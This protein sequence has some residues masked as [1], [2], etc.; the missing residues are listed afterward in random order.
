LNKNYII[1][2]N[3]NYV[4]SYDYSNNELYHKYD[5]N[6]KG[7]HFILIIHNS[8][9]IIKLIESCEDG[10]IRIWHF[11]SGLLLNKIKII[12]D[13][14]NGICLLND[15]YYLFVGCDD[16]TIK[17]ID[18]KNN[19]IINEI[20]GHYKPVLTIKTFIHPKMGKCLISQG[21]E[22]DQIKIWTIKS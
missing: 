2:A 21:Y 3:L 12:D 1:T 11:H 22:D 13:N 20:K 16:E 19:I 8:E 9:D 10:I 17:V 4:I 6:G 5:D 7:Y 18:L 15:N 14:L